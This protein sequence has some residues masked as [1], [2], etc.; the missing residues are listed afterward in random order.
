MTNKTKETMIVSF[1]EQWHLS[2]FKIHLFDERGRAVV[3]PQTNRVR[4]GGRKELVRIKPGDG[5]SGYLSP[6]Y[7]IQRG[8]YQ[9]SVTFVHTT[10]GSNVPQK[11][12]SNG[13]RKTFP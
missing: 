5:V 3:L 11:V 13:I 12:E 2:W 1:A 10:P 7:Q 6:D 9:I 4:G 8:R